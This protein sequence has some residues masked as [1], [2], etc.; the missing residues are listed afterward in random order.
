MN[1]SQTSTELVDSQQAKRLADFSRR[2]QGLLGQQ[3]E[4]ARAQRDVTEH[5]DSVNQF[6][7]I[8]DAVTAALESLSHDVFERQ[9]H[10]IEKAI[11]KALQDVLE[12]PIE[13]KAAASFKNNATNVDFSI[14]RDGNEEDIMKG[15]GG[16]VANVVSVGLRLFAIAMLDERRHRK[17]LVLD[18]QDCW[19]HPSLVPRLTKIVQ[20]AGT[21]LGF[22][23]LMIS[24]HD[25]SN[26]LR[27]A[28]RV[29]RLTPD[30]GSGVKIEQIESDEA[31]ISQRSASQP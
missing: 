2:A 9:L 31:I 21:A 23:V 27:Y 6:L 5:L 13:F 19:L 29:Y 7:S 15:Q 28:D 12:Q 18:E 16:S 11:T 20:E 24:H 14:L 17:F 10:E 8:S 25:V 4:L 30:T 1:D 22:Q 3:Q 26:F